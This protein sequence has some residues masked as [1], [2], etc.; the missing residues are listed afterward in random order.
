MIDPV[1]LAKARTH[2]HAG[3]GS[4]LGVLVKWIPACAGM[5]A[6]P[7]YPTQIASHQ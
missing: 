1:M 5:T 3:R 6:T 7:G 2:R 4:R